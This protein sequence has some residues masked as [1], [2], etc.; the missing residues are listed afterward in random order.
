MQ[1]ELRGEALLAHRQRRHVL[2]GVRNHAALH[3]VFCA[4]LL[5][6]PGIGL[7]D[8]AGTQLR[9][10]R[11]LDLRCDDARGDGGVQL[12]GQQQVL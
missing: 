11:R 2:D 10:L 4:S 1:V 7:D 9:E 12:E 5:V 6:W 3:G 8:H